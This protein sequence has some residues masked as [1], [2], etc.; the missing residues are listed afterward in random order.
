MNSSDLKL[1]SV[2]WEHGM[3]L[4][5]DHFLRQERYFDSLFLWILRYMTNA[6][7]LVGAGPRVPENEIGA[8]RHDPVVSL[9]EDEEQLTI[10]VSQCRGITP[11]GCII[12]IDPSSPVSR[13]FP[14]ADLEGIQEAPVYILA[15]P[16][17]KNPAEGEA[18][19]FNPQMQTER[20]WNYRLSLQPSAESIPYSLVAAQI[21]RQ[22]Y[23][24]GFEKNPDFIPA[25]TTMAS[26]SE[27]AAGWRKIVEEATFLAERY[28]ELHRAMREY[29]ILFT[30]R[31]IETEV[32]TQTVQFVDRMVAALQDLVYELLDW[33]QPPQRFFGELRKFLHAAA[34]Y[35][36]LTPGLQ[37]YYDTL[38]EVGETEF[39]QLINQ[40]KR[41]LRMTRTWRVQDDLGIEVRSALASLAA[42]QRLERALEGKYVDFR[43]SPQ[44]EAMNFVFDRGGNVL[45]K[46]AAKPSRVQGVG[47]DMVTFFS[48]LRLEGRDKYRL[49]L[50]GEHNATFEKG[51]RIPAEI[52]INEGSGFQRAPLNLVSEAVI[53]GQTNFEFDFEAPDVPTI[54]DVRVAVPAH[55]PIRTALLFARHRFYA[56]RA[57]EPAARPVQPIERAPEPAP[58]PYAPPPHAA[59]P[60]PAAPPQAAPPYTPPAAP[61]GA[62]PQQPPPYAPPHGAPP[63]APPFQQQPPPP[64]EE[65]KRGGAPW[66][67]FRR[68]TGAPPPPEPPVTPPQAPPRQPGPPRPRFDQ[69]EEPP[70]PPPPRRRRLE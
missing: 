24:A 9:H 65:P 18:D 19:E 43:V 22:R 13:R 5:P 26:H 46:L 56:G 68:A 47:D 1:R 2:N 39:I 8:A 34:V 42:L 50:V 20:Q 57:Q 38:K 36:D 12:D 33:T 35:F 28:A 53:P 61:Y 52:R 48:Q 49:I 54:T 7:G 25:C 21:R 3:L 14:R 41:I 44:L 30:E 27:L 31:G 11:A 29:L 64:P 45:Y 6:R 67:F 32:D 40:Q 69:G 51:T 60:P 62:P 63:A 23:G 17:D 15:A 66:E 37:T 10:T 16:H 58:P 55:L 59:P 70:A 4:A